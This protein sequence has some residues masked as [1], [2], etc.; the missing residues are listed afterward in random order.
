MSKKKKKEKG[1]FSELSDFAKKLGLVLGPMVGVATITHLAW[2]NPLY[3]K[4]SVGATI[5]ILYLISIELRIKKL[6]KKC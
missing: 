5:F 2:G 4:I 3:T 1:I 6:E